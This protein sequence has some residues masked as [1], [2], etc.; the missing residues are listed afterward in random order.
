MLDDAVPVLLQG[1]SNLCR[2]SRQNFT[3]N[4]NYHIPC[5]QPMLIPAKAFAKQSFQ[6][7]ALHRPGYL[8]PGNSES[9]ARTVTRI[10]RNQDCHPGVAASNIVLKNL[11]EIDRAG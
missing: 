1:L 6:R 9:Q 2:F 10:L 8:F 3:S 11:L 4:H 5:R 7:I